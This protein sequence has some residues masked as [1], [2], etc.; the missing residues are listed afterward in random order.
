MDTSVHFATLYAGTSKTCGVTDRGVLYCW[1]RA[2]TE[3]VD[4]NPVAPVHIGSREPVVALAPGY[5]FTCAA[6]G[7]G[8]TY[9]WREIPWAAVGDEPVDDCDGA[10]VCLPERPVSDSL[11]F[12]ALGAGQENA[13]GVTTTGD[14]YC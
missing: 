7:D 3:I 14:L 12:R 2:Y 8:R 1:G 11:R 6:V 9:C 10:R 13:C 4:T 5:W